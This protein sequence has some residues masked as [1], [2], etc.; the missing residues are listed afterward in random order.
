[1]E[2][3]ARVGMI[4]IVGTQAG[5]VEDLDDPAVLHHPEPVSKM[6]DDGEVV[7]DRDVGKPVFARQ[8]PQ[9]VQ[10]FGLD[11]DNECR[12]RFVAVVRIVGKGIGIGMWIEI[13]GRPQ[14]KDEA[15]LA[16]AVDEATRVLPRA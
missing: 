1:M 6:A 7:A 8:A 14:R 4:G 13:V 5:D 2:E 11:R 10:H 16:C 15:M 3:L 12:G 9:Q